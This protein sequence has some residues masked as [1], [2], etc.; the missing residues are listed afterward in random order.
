MNGSKQEEPN[1]RTWPR[2]I[3]AL[4]LVVGAPADVPAQA[5][6]GIPTPSEFHGFDVGSRYIVTSRLVDYYRLL[7]DQSPR[8][9][10][11]EYGRSIQGRPL[12]MLIVGSEA[13]LAR[14]EE[15]RS[16]LHRLADP[17]VPLDGGPETLLEGLPAV[18]WLFIVDTDE[19]AGVNVLQEVAHELATSEA[20]EI[21]S[22][23]EHV[24]TVLTPLTNPDSHARYVN[25]HMLYDVS[26]ASVDQNAVENDAHWGMN[27]DGNAYGIDVNRDFGVFVTPEMQAL[28]R[29]ATAWRPQLWLDIHSGPDVIFIP[30]FPGPYHP[31]WPEQAPGWWELLA[32]QASD[33]FG[34]KG[35]T[36]NSREGYEGVTS[37]TFGLS[38]GMLGPAVSGMLFETF[39]GRPGK[40][41]AFIR[42]D[43]SL[44][45]MRMAMERHREGIFSLLQVARDNRLELLGDARRAVAGAMEEARSNAE[46]SIIIPA[47]GPGVDPEKVAR[48]VRRLT[49]QGVRVRRATASFSQPARGFLE[50]EA[51][52]RRFA[53]GSYVVD[54]VQPQ[55][56]LARSLLDPTIDYD[57]PRIEVPFRT[58]MPYYDSS[59][60]NLALL[61]GVSAYASREPVSVASEAVE[62]SAVSGA[63]GSHQAL[64]RPEPPYAWVM[65]A[66]REASYRTAIELMKE[67]YRVRVFRFPFQLDGERYGKGTF[68]VLRGRNPDDVESAVVEAA[69]RHGA[70][71][72]EVAGPF[73]DAGTSF[74]DDSRLA[75]IQR[76]LV[77]VVADWPVT[78]DHTFGGIRNTLES[79]FGFTFSP[80][81]L[82]TLET[83]TD[84]QKYT[85]IVLPHAGMSVRGGPNFNAG[86]RGRLEDLAR[87][88]RYVREGGTLIAVK[89]AAAFVANDPV[90]G[91]G[92][93]AEGWAER[94]DGAT[95]RAEWVGERPIPVGERLRWQPGMQDVGPHMLG[96]GYPEGD[97]AAPGLYPVLLAVDAEDGA[98]VAARYSQSEARLLLDGFMVPEDRPRLAGRPFAVVA[99]VGRGRVIYFADDPTF[100]GYW[101]GLN[102]LF[103]NSVMFGPFL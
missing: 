13:N 50:G 35:W 74:G 91:A 25:W 48:L 53:A 39:G 82:A 77:A 34:R 2:A 95:L 7:G 45:T 99:P 32:R 103:L 9:L 26:G 15:I 51:G 10:Y 63:E 64:E 36:F 30:P 46:R 23:R 76:P 83:A 65:P 12:P 87:L 96:A 52:R 37:V 28:A 101:Y 68:A 67:G 66:G 100:R 17:A 72:L 84:L 18:V 92:V 31:L 38:W 57:D 40:T 3:M 1:R 42:S 24:I 19:E 79:D 11:E 27:T 80:V 81:M 16:A 88:R 4:A 43:G 89:G 49:L 56:R 75:A 14:R 69:R 90:L 58:K 41:T 21:Q 44:A 60:G 62:E 47:S 55:A 6:S 5:E 85:A 71:L 54:L 94:T 93:T 73:T 22:I 98:E 70:E 102:I 29:A 61:F 33:N 86:Y 20:P 59:W 78:Q 97:F 8:V